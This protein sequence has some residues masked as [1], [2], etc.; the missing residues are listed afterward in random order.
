MIDIM[1]EILGVE[2][3]IEV[4]TLM[5]VMEFLRK[6]SMSQELF[7]CIPI[8]TAAI[9]CLECTV[10]GWTLHASVDGDDI[11]CKN[12]ATFVAW[13]E[14]YLVDSNADLRA[15]AH[16]MISCVRDEM[17]KEYENFAA[18]TH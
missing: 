7:N 1:S 8:G 12:D 18:N 17:E 11:D 5:D 16:R 6:Q 13:G 4:P 2:E 15:C 3:R 9:V 10:D 14:I